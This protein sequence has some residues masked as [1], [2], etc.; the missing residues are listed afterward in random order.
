MNPCSG[1]PRHRTDLCGRIKGACIDVAGLQAEDHSV[2]SSS[3]GSAV[4]AHSSLPVYW[5]AH[6]AISASSP[7]RPS[8]FSNELWT[9]SPTI[10]QVKFRSAEEPIVLHIPSGTG[11]AAFDA[12]LQGRRN[13]PWSRR[14]PP[15]RHNPPA[16]GKQLP[17]PVQRNLLG[18]VAAGDL[19]RAPE[20]GILIPG[21][22]KPGRGHAR[23]VDILR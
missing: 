3:C 18:R 13:L 20:P 7:S 15:R 14:S 10:T 21:A 4:G 22:H 1:L 23:P 19:P 16:D 12:R 2:R 5:H 17:H 9:S 6:H 11:P 8:A